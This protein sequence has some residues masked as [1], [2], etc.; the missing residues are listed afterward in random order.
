MESVR[1]AFGFSLVVLAFALV[2]ALSTYD[3][4]DPSFN[5]ATGRLPRNW[6]GASGAYG[7]DFLFETIG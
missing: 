5:V 6:M 3:S 2:V 1:R 4:S 7:A